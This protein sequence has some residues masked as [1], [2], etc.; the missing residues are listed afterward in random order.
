MQPIGHIAG[1]GAALFG[2]VGTVMAV[3]IATFIGRF[4]DVTALPL[5]VG[6]AACGALSLLLIQYLKLL[7]KRKSS[8]QDAKLQVNPHIVT[9]DS[10]K[11][12]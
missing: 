9:E 1:I 10:S 12:Y 7:N 8:E 6:F 5:F 4:I 11:S 2:F 3:P